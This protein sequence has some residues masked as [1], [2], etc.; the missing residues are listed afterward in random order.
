MRRLLRLSSV[1]VVLT[2]VA[3]TGHAQNSQPR[4]D[5]RRTPP[6]QQ[7]APADKNA[8]AQNPAPDQSQNPVFRAGIDFVR[9]DVIASDRSGNAIADLKMSDFD[10][11]EDGK[12]QKL[13]TFKLIKLDGGTAPGP[14][15]PPRA[16]RNDADEET[17]AAKDDVRLFAV[18]LDDYHVKEGSSLSARAAIS[19]WVDTQLGPS[20]MIG[21]MRPLESI[22]QV[23]MTRNHSAISRAIEQFRGRKGNYTP[24]N[25]IEQNYSYYPAETV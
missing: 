15:G 20:D 8:A 11:T 2:M 22:E 3:L 5:D 4:Q 17:E 18:F 14:D 6:A 13:E 9:V 19:K 21:V 25:E 12:P 1:G 10:V 7:D 16:I 23:R 24:Q